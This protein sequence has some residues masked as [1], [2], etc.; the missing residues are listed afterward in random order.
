M[1]DSKLRLRRTSQVLTPVACEEGFGGSF[2]FRSPERTKSFDGNISSRIIPNNSLASPNRRIKRRVKRRR[3]RE[4]VWRWCKLCLRGL[5]TAI[6]SATLSV[7]LLPFS[8]TQVDYHHQFQHEVEYVFQKLVENRK[9]YH[10]VIDNYH[11]DGRSRIQ[12]N[13]R[14]FVEYT[15]SEIDRRKNLRIPLTLS[16]ASKKPEIIKCSDGSAGFKNDDYCDCPLD[17]LDE[18]D[19]SACSNVLVQK[20]KFICGRREKDN[21]KQQQQQQQEVWIYASRVN[22][23]I[24]DCPDGSDEYGHIMDQNKLPI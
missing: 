10:S 22:D 12:G 8:W 20:K 19:T 3:R 16:T 4:V 14:M 13:D 5:L 7:G 17:G 15:D 1:D 18:P 6:I 11:P 2:R 21:N 23:G 24:V 9:N